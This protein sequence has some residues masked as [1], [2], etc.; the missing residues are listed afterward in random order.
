MLRYKRANDLADGKDVLD[1]PCGVGWGT[2][3]LSDAKSVM[4]VDID[5]EAVNY[6]K[7]HYGNDK[8]EF[9]QGSMTKMDI[10]DRKFDLITCLEGIE[11]V[12]KEDAIE[13]LQCFS[14][15]LRED[16]KVYMTAPVFE[17]GKNVYHLHSYNKDELIEIAERFFDIESSEVVEVT[18]E[19]HVVH[20]IMTGKG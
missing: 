1:C 6:A 20:L 14:N 12:V 17:S 10:G 8:M 19:L 5:D 2:S 7:N 11:H 16:G 9:L 3:L 13:A 18:S 4:G 15:C